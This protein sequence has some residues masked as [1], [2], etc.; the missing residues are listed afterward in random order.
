MLQHQCEEPACAIGTGKEATEDRIPR[1]ESGDTGR[2]HGL[3]LGGK[4]IRPPLTNQI[5]QKGPG[6]LPLAADAIPVAIEPV[7]VGWQDLEPPV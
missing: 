7:G 1:Q 2:G 5:A 3:A 6:G 4:G